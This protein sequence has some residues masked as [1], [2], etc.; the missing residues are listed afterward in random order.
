MCEFLKSNAF[1]PVLADLET[2]CFS[3]DEY[4]LNLRA[5]ARFIQKNE[6][7][8]IIQDGKLLAYAVIIRYQRVLRI[9]SIAVDPAQ[10][11]KGYGEQ[12]IAFIVKAAR[13]LRKRSVMLE[14][15]ASNEPAICLYEKMGFQ[16]TKILTKYY[17]DG[18]DGIKMIKK[19]KE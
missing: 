13:K 2:A 14:V 17:A 4:P 10:R 11:R 8:A 16:K 9:Y 19:L 6:V 7:V 1:L 3:Q 18:A 15:K 5:I 12:L